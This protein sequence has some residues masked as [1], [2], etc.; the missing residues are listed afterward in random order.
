[1]IAKLPSHKSPGPDGLTGEYKQFST[2][3]A[4][5][6][7]QVCNDAASSS[8]L[9]PEMLNALIITLPKP[10]KE[11]TSPQNF[12]PISL[13][14][15]DTKI[16]AKLIATRLIDIMPSLIHPDQSGFTKGRQTCAAT[17]RLINIIHHS[18]STGTPSLLLSLDAE[19]AF[20][21][22]NW[23]YL[24]ATLKK[25]V[26][27]G[28]ILSAIMALYSKPSAQVYTSELLSKPFP[29]TNGTHQ[30]C[31]L[32]PLIFNLIMEPLAEHIRSNLSI[33]ASKSDP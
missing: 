28:H 30:G 14:N 11:H 26:L 17:R 29:I 12:R 6:L 33:R 18:N 22:V 10:G 21:R 23:A 31:P 32:S 1:M 4:P 8:S 7:S 20:D 2:V 5:F 19:K 16:Y 3:L 9:P 24:Q 13:L 15:I 27:R 25:F